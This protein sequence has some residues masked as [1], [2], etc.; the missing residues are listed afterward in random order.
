MDLENGIARIRSEEKDFF[1]NWSEYDM[2][3]REISN[4]NWVMIALE[5]GQFTGEGGR[6]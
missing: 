5:L 6:R 2:I 3:G 1:G 4:F